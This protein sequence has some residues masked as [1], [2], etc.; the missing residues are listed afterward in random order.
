MAVV[1]QHSNKYIRAGEITQQQRTRKCPGVGA[2]CGLS[3]QVDRRRVSDDRDAGRGLEEE[4]A[5]M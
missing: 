2:M 5:A 1:R 3:G 4:V